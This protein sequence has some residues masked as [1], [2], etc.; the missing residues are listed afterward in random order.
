MATVFAGNSEID[1]MNGLSYDSGNTKSHFGISPKH[2]SI[3]E[4]GNTRTPS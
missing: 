2:L 1:G 3:V 4:S